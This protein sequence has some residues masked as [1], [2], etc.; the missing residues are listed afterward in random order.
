MLPS[1][2]IVWLNVAPAK[3]VPVVFAPSISA[4]ERFAPL[5]FAPERSALR[6]VADRR[7]AFE[8]M[9]FAPETALAAPARGAALVV[10]GDGAL[11]PIVKLSALHAAIVDQRDSTQPR[12]PLP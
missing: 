5:K 7:E 11:V 6:R 8:K 2:M 10:P 12:K 9:A 1:D 3:L 4:P